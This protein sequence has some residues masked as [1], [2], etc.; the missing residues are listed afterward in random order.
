[1]APTVTDLAAPANAVRGVSVPR[2][3]ALDAVHRFQDPGRHYPGP[4]GDALDPAADHEPE[5]RLRA[6]QSGG[7]SDLAVDRQQPD[8]LDRGHRV[9][10]DSR[11]PRRLRLLAPALAGTGRPFQHAD[12][13]HVGARAGA[14]DPDVPAD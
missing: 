14:A 4:G 1:M 9:G 11:L 13:H 6:R 8:Y 3:A 2:A 12:R 7:V 10:P 5:L